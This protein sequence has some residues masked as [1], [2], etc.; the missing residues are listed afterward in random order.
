MS[1]E[2][3]YSGEIAIIGM[4]GRFPGAKDI[5][6]YWENLRAGKECITM[7]TDE[8]LSGAGVPA[9]LLANPKYVKAKGMMAGTELFDASYFGINPREAELMDP[10]HRL[11]LE[12]SVEALENAGYDP[13]RYN[14]RI[15]VFA[16][17]GMNTYI[18][19][20]LS[21]RR[22]IEMV[23]GFQVMI[24]NDKDY[25]PTLT[26]YKLNLRGPSVNVQTACSTA[27]VAVHLA[28][29]SL[30]QGECDMALA[31]AT[32]VAFPQKGGYMYT[33]GGI[34]SP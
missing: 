16:G 21:N 31:G 2:S 6:E 11:F 1:N 24:T 12:C 29:Q 26:S 19:N 32:S 33:E 22:L 27:L 7:F 34:H 18:L 25:V 20:L 3:D 9:D 23:G 13:G 17:A 28:C 15:G 14:D 8:E 4:A 10:Q 30:I 5:D